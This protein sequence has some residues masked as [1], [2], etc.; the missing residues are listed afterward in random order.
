MMARHESRGIVLMASLMGA[1]PAL[2]QTPGGAPATPPAALTAADYA[3]A[4]T[5]MGYNTTPLVLGAGVRPTWLPGER[6][7]YRVSTANGNEFVLVDP[8]RATRRPAFDHARLA[9]ALSQAAGARYE[10]YQ[11]PFTE[12]EFAPGGQ[13]IAFTAGAREWSCDLTTYR[14]QRGSRHRGAPGRPRR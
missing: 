5:F 6:F 8:A 13:A 9:A 4:E 7:W 11:L 1:F 2:S 12:F 14:W 3:R 10:A